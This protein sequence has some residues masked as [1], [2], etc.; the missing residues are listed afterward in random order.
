M[1][2]SQPFTLP[3]AE[4]F[5]VT[6]AN[7]IDY[8]ISIGLPRSYGTTDRAYPVIFV[9]D[10]DDY[11]CTVLERARGRGTIGEIEELVVV[12][13]GCPPGTD[14]GTYGARRVYDFSTEDWSPESSTYRL[15]A[16]S[17][18]AIGQSVRLGGA[19]LL[20]RFLTEELQPLVT[21]RYRV[22]A[23][24]QALFGHS[25]AGN[26]VGFALFTKPGSFAKIYIAA[27][28]GFAY[29]DW[30]AFRLEEQYATAHDDL[31]V[32]LYLAAGS[33]KHSVLELRHRQRHGSNGGD[34]E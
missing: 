33:D 23:A 30:E 29:N 13:I 4:A 25:S 16:D 24:E 19:P 15:F 6:S 22:E 26:F 12:G 8:R 14:L 27:C 20:L 28:P 2:D 7:G 18:G 21:E 31:P 10:G 1:S 34:S 11:F 17:M 5:D 3:H 32:T 9:L